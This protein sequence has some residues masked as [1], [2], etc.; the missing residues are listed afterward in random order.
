MLK[1]G[2]VYL[3]NSILTS[4]GVLNPEIQFTCK[5]LIKIIILRGGDGTAWFKTC[6]RWRNE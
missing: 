3:L 2:F 1:D 4:S 5:Y 6:F